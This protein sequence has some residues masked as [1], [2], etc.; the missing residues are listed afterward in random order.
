[1]VDDERRVG[2]VERAVGVG[3]R[4]AVAD[5]ELE[6]GDAV[7]RGPRDPGGLDHLGPLVDRG[8]LHRPPAPGGVGQQRSSGCR[9]RRCRRRSASAARRGRPAARSRAGSAA[10]R[11]AAGSTAAGRAGCRRA[12]RGPRAA[13][14]AAPPHR[15]GVPSEE[16]TSALGAAGTLGAMARPPA[17]RPALAPAILAT[18][19]I[20]RPRRRTRQRGDR[21]R[22]PRPERGRPRHGR[23]RDPGALPLPPAR[24]VGGRRR[25]RPRRH[26]RR[27]QPDRR[28]RRRDLRRRRRSRRSAPSRRAAGCPSNGVVDAATWSALVVPLGPGSTGDAVQALQ[29]ELRE[30]RGATSV[31]IDGRL[32]DGDDRR[33]EGVPGPHGPAADGLDGRGDV[34]VARLALRAAAVLGVGALRLRSAGE[35]ELGHG[36]ADLDDRGGRPGDGRRR[37]RPGRG[38]RPRATSTAATTRSTPPTRSD[39]M[40]TCG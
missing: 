36:R 33:G 15:R 37:L 4:P 25:V 32:R 14:R 19:A 27:P 12:P 18:L 7:D 5:D 2:D 22:V 26:D 6:A 10:P 28:S 35:R 31:P 9:R 1:M 23:R 20:A 8:D 40:R 16:A 38:R 24:G 11:R 29:R 30:K 13:R 21:R 3:Q 34:A 17:R 39:S